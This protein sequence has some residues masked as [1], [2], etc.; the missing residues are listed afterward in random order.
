MKVI[1]EHD[2]KVC[3]Y[4]GQYTNHIVQLSRNYAILDIGEK[5]LPWLKEMTTYIEPNFAIELCG[6]NESLDRIVID[7]Q[8]MIIA[9]IGTKQPNERIDVYYNMNTGSF[10]QAPIK[11]RAKRDKWINCFSENNQIKASDYIKCIDFLCNLSKE[12]NKPI[13]IYSNIYVPNK[14]FRYRALTYKIVNHF[15]KDINGV[16]IAKAAQTDVHKYYKASQSPYESYVERT[17]FLE[18]TIDQA[19]KRA[20]P[21][22]NKDLKNKSSKEMYRYSRQNGSLYN[23]VF[24]QSIDPNQDIYVLLDTGNYQS[25]EYYES[26]GLEAIPVF[27]DYSMLYAKKSAF[28]ALSETLRNQVVPQYQMPIASYSFCSKNGVDRPIPYSI[29]PE[30]LQYRGRGAYIGVIVV[31]GVDYTS[32]VLR[33]RDGTS[34]IAYIWE[35]TQADSG[36]NYFKEQINQVLAGDDSIQMIEVPSGDSTGTMM[37]SIAGGESSNGDYRGVATEAEFLVANINRAPE[38]MQSIFGGIPSE[39][40]A[41]IPDVLIGAI[42]LM[43]FA[44]EQGRPLTLCIPFNT[45]IDP[46]DGSY[47]LNQLLGFMSQRSSVTIITPTGEEADKMHHQTFN[48]PEET[49]KIVNLR[50]EKES[51][52]IVGVLYYK[53][54]TL[55]S[56]LLYTPEGI[57]IEPVSLKAAN[58]VRIDEQST[59]YSSGEV[60]DYANGARRILFRLESPAV[61]GW[62]I[63]LRSEANIL[64]QIDIWLAQQELNPYTTLRPSNPFITAGSTATTVPLMSVGGYN[65]DSMV[66]LKTSGRG[67]TWDDRVKPLFIT[68]ASDIL[69]VCSQ[70]ELVGVTSTLV[71]SSIMLGV[72]AVLYSKFIEEGVIPLPNTLIMNGIILRQT[73][74]FENVEYPNQSQGYG[75]FDTRALSRLLST[76]FVL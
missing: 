54:V 13:T 38:G 33:N 61:G 16:L 28:D 29:I 32:N 45:N 76:P 64:S 22:L 17:V 1:V 58:I 41:L 65:K 63:E 4:L 53:F 73:E 46:H 69:A 66:V 74:Q 21:F 75:I 36:Q 44:R 60:L 71:A 27:G 51:Q 67:Y 9:L 10:T 59:I 42:K 40:G 31:D 39:H 52:N 5:Y 68:H 37:L 24:Y 3:G 70:G 55:A 30:T 57:G 35:Q 72:I 19:I 7:H 6:Q 26:L 14:T 34:R 43:D 20:A 50:V 25:P 8:D 12:L 15:L 18:D 56:V 23:D 2:E 47:I 49:L 48:G 62:R 11:H